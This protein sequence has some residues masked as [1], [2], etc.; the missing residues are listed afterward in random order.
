M[1]KQWYYTKATLF[2]DGAKGYFRQEYDVYREVEGEDIEN[3]SIK[4][5]VEGHRGEDSARIF[6]VDGAHYSTL[7]AAVEA[8]GLTYEGPEV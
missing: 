2:A 8:R 5:I 6:D 3:L 1:A 7:R 4:C